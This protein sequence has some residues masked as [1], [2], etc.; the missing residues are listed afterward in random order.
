[1]SLEKADSS[2]YSFLFFCTVTFF[3]AS[4]SPL[5]LMASFADGQNGILFSK[6]TKLIRKVQVIQD[7]FTIEKK[8]KKERVWSQTKEKEP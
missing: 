6:G 8:K 7:L 2:V 5:L 1:M 3:I 4:K